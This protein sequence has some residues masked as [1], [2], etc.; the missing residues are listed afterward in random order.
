MSF[1]SSKRMD[2]HCEFI[3]SLSSVEY[4]PMA[5]QRKS[6]RSRLILAIALIAASSN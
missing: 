6:S 5:I 2:V 4:L 3:A 1:Y